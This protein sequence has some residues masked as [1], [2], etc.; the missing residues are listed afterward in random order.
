MGLGLNQRTNERS[1]SQ[2]GEG[3]LSS[4]CSRHQLPAASA[5]VRDGKAD[6]GVLNAECDKIAGV[7]IKVKIGEGLSCSNLV[8]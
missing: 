4:A 5:H 3:K 8:G 1:S 2:K 6:F 7:C